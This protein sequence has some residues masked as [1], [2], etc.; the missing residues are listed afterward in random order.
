MLYGP[1]NWSL[2]SLR[3]QGAI[4]SRSN[5]RCRLSRGS[6]DCMVK[7]KLGAVKP[8]HSLL[9]VPRSNSLTRQEQISTAVR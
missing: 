5:S 4:R 3:N 8:T 2:T 7:W 6:L 9:R 1:S